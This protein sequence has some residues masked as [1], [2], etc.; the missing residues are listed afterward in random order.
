MKRDYSIIG[1]EFGDLRVLAF[2][3]SIKK[4][5]KAGARTFW[6]CLCLVCG[7]ECVIERNNLVSGNTNSCGCQWGLRERV[8]YLVGCN[9]STVSTVLT[10]GK[11]KGS[12]GTIHWSLADRIRAVAKLVG[13]KGRK[14]SD[15]NKREIE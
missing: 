5:P 8:A 2:E 6:R 4:T 11:H 10:G 14:Y 15:P 13:V 7:Q 1:K 3:E 9:A 12:Q